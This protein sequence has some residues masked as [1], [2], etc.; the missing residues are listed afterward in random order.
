MPWTPKQIHLFQAAAHN[1]K[2][3]AKV[4]IKPAKAA[5]MSKEGVKAPAKAAPARRGPRPK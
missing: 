2:F 1:P 3:A 5:E 4:G